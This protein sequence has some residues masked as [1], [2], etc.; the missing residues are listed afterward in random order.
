MQYVPA[1]NSLADKIILVT[2]ASKGIGKSISIEYARHGATV[3]LL[4]RN[5]KALS[6]TYDEITKKNYTQP[7]IY[8]FNLATASADNFFELA[9]IIKQNFGRLDGVLLNAG[10]VGSLAPIEYY[11]I[12]QW[13]QVMQLNLNSSFLLIQALL[14]L[15]KQSDTTSVIFTVADQITRSQAN[16]GAYAV[17]CNGILSLMQILADEFANRNLRFNAINP[18]KVD[19]SLRD[20][21]YPG[22]SPGIVATAA[23]LHGVYVYLM[24][25]DSR[26]TTGKV[27]TAT[28]YL[29]KYTDC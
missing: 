20:K 2:G 18:G 4:A 26:P 28:D 9:N 5:I 12:E 3:I 10:I 27:F 25:Q 6:S 29:V 19:T 7:A 22:G 17:A 13:Y 11:S 21:I 16:W 15:L 8:P 23:D 1:A 24:S 14:P